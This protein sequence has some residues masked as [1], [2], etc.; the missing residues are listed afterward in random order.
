[1]RKRQRKL[2]KKEG[3]AQKKLSVQSNQ[4]EVRIEEKR[5][6]NEV[7]LPET[8]TVGDLA[9][10][11][12]RSSAEIIRVLISN[13]M[14]I[15]IND[16][17]DFETAE[18]IAPELDLKISKQKLSKP[19][20][21]TGAGGLLPRPPVVVVMGHVDHG[22]TSLLDRIRSTNIT[23]GES[24]GITQH[25]GAYQVDWKTEE[26]EARKITF[27]DTP[28][29]EAFSAMR[30]HGANI[31]DVVVLVVSAEEG[32]KP[33]TKEA[34]S[35]AKAANVPIIVA[36]TKS[37]LPTAN[38]EKVKSELVELELSPEDW[39]GKTP[40]LL[41]SAKTGEGI[42]DLLTTIILVAYLA[43]LKS[44][45]EGLAEGVVI[46]SHKAV[47]IGP[48]ATILIKEGTLRISD[49]F[50]IDNILGKVRFL[51]DDSGKRLSE[52]GPS[53]P[54]RVAGLSGVP[55]FGSTLIAANSEKEA[56]QLS[57]TVI[58]KATKS[59]KA[60][61]VQDNVVPVILKADVD[62]SIKAL[63]Q[64]LEAINVEDTTVS[65]I[66]SGVGDITESD[67]HMAASTGAYMAAFRVGISPAARRIANSENLKF[68][69]Y[70]V[71]Y[72]LVDDMMAAAQGAL[73]T[74]LVEVEIGKLK[75]KG[76]FRT[77]KAIKIVGGKI[78]EGKVVKGCSVK[79]KRKDEVIDSG[80]VDSVQRGQTTTD[81]VGVGEECGLLIEI[82]KPIEI[83]DVLVFSTQ[84]ERVVKKTDEQEEVVS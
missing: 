6:V 69:Q 73:K 65:I 30:A 46:E 14:L 10:L 50:Y 44:R 5:S 60:V 27:I 82:T 22:K 84:E 11:S 45:Q 29:H 43:D 3:K 53:T 76:V 17:I 34:V 16:S 78:E 56:R 19:K 70:E 40:T 26:G 58:S 41:V 31:T 35:H 74:E 20:K 37:D 28:G 49:N 54:V 36:L 63:Q 79:I 52:A 21:L 15:N 2:S 8:V 33:Q 67:A 72:D 64:S 66:H 80:E 13:G 25:I 62:G 77:T 23:A 71:I 4:P 42:D 75:V 7:D 61:E 83:D 51:E 9:Q 38:P 57:S 48:V 24:G 68:K 18:I 32:V 81:E 55:T 12:G 1:M 39:G 59:S 47:G